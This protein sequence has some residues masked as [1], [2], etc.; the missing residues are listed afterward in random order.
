MT[1]IAN[2]TSRR[3]RERRLR[4]IPLLIIGTVAGVFVLLFGMVN[5]EWIVISFPGA[6][7]SNRFSWPAF[8]A[9]IW[10]VMLVCY[11]VGA[12]TGWIL[13][14]FA[15]SGIQRRAL[16]DEARIQ[17]LEK[18]LEKTHRLLSSTRKAR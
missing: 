15:K 3:E 5:D 6:P 4:L 10:A 16:D 14:W 7:W 1:F 18:E 9:R 8:E 17:S 13:W 2:N 12:G 11:G